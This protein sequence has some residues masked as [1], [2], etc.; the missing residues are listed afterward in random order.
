MRLSRTV[1]TTLLI[2][3][4]IILLALSL[5]L[6]AS[7]PNNISIGFWLGI[8]SLIAIYSGLLLRE[9]KSLKEFIRQSLSIGLIAIGIGLLVIFLWLQLLNQFNLI[10]GLIGVSIS[11]TGWLLQKTN[12]SIIRNIISA[13]LITIGISLLVFPILIL[14][15]YGTNVAFANIALT[16]FVVGLLVGLIGLS[17]RQKKS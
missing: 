6:A 14:T 1:L 10:C 13:F 8:S 9:V 7:F 17:I 4:G 11:T 5:W 15:I 16:Y 3:L 12:L 2:V